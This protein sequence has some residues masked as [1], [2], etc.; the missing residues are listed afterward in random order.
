VDPT[1]S[2]ADEFFTGLDV[3]EEV[4]QEPESLKEPEARAPEPE[5]AKSGEGKAPEVVKAP[6]AKAPEPAKPVDTQ[7]DPQKWVPVGA[8]V[9]L[10]NQM[11]AMQAKLAALENPPKPKP[12]VPEFTT[13]PK[14]YVDSKLAAALE[15]L[16]T[17][18]KPVTQTAQQA[19]ATAEETRFMHALNTG[20]QAF[21]SQTPDYYNALNHLRQIRVTELVTLNPELTQEQVR[22]II[23]REELTLAANL[24]RSGRNPHEVAYTLAKARGYAPKAPDPAPGAPVLPVVATTKQLPPDQT[25]GS[26]SGTPSSG[27]VFLEDDEV[28]DKAFG[29]MFGRKR[30]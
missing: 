28:F 20:E 25:L 4:P 10:R 30:A 11:K 15:Q 19:A 5:A 29:E 23:G 6:E 9:E 13:D 18:L 21:L 26:G 14:G 12:E 8:H 1:Q 2:N 3:A 7:P 22:D 16:E 27:E 17:G 24:M